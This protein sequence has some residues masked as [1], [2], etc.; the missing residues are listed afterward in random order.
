MVSPL[1]QHDSLDDLSATLDRALTMLYLLNGR[2]YE[3]EKS[4]RELRAFAGLD[5]P[6]PSIGPDWLGLKEAAFQTGL[7]QSGVRWRI[8]TGKIEAI[9]RGG[10]L[11]IRAASINRETAR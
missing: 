8:A 10:R 2:T 9:K 6:K 4:N 7:S 11:L 5:P 3:L 1:H